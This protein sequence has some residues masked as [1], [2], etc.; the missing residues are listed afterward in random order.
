MNTKLSAG[1]EDLNTAARLDQHKI[2][3]SDG[4]ILTSHVIAEPESDDLP[5]HLPYLTSGIISS[6]GPTICARLGRKSGGERSRASYFGRGGLIPTTSACPNG[7]EAC[8][9]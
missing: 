2:D 4:M 6:P 7:G 5:W 3:E 9:V 8:W 1:K